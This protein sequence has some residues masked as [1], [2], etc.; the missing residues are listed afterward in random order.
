[1]SFKMQKILIY[2]VLL[3]GILHTTCG[4]FFQM[5]E[6]ERKCFIQETPGDTDVV[7]EYKMEVVDP[8]SGGFMPMP[9]GV[10]MHVDIRDS[11]NKIILSRVYNS[12]ACLKFTTYWP[13]DHRICL[14][15]NSSAFFQGALV[16]VH[17]DIRAGDQTVDYETIRRHYNLDDMQLRVLQLMNQADQISKEQNYQR[18]REQRFRQTSSNI[19]NNIILWCIAQAVILI[20]LWAVQYHF[21]IRKKSLYTY[22][23][24]ILSEKELMRFTTPEA[25]RTLMTILGINGQGLTTS[26]ISQWITQVEDPESTDEKTEIIV[27]DKLQAKVQEFVEKFLIKP[28]PTIPE[29]RKESLFASNVQLTNLLYSAQRNRSVHLKGDTF[30]LVC[31]C[32]DCKASNPNEVEAKK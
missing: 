20:L 10:G 11:D 18:F 21:L 30:L 1:M 32:N 19:Y 14:Q 13:G 6:K 28:V 8:R 23:C 5:F 17:L 25:F 29:N 4:M 12:K 9:F 26:A 31:E 15:T 22:Y 2:L 24:Q 7:V 3:L 27:G 16:R